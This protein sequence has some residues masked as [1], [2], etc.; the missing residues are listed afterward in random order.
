MEDTEVRVTRF[1]QYPHVNPHSTCVGFTITCITTGVSIYRDTLISYESM[2][3]AS[4]QV[5]V[6][7]AWDAIKPS[8]E[9]WYNNQN[10]ILGQVF[11]AE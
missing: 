2:P 9:T 4:G 3:G 7:S 5:I 11:T 8:V 10:I 6:K 1:E